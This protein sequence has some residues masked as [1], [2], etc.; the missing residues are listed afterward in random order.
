MFVLD[1][2]GLPLSNTLSVAVSAVLATRMP[3][4]ERTPFVNV[5]NSDVP[6]L[7]AVPVLLVTVGT[8][9]LGDVLSPLKVSV[10]SPL[11]VVTV[12]PN[13]S[14][15]VIVS[16]SLTPTVGVVLAAVI[17]Y[18]LA[19][20][21]DTVKLTPAPPVEV[22]DR[23]PSET[24]SV[25][26]STFLATRTP[27]AELT[28]LVNVINSE[29]PSLTGVPVL[30]VIVGTLPAS[31]VPSP[32]KVSVLSPLKLV[33]V[34]PNWSTCVIVSWSLA[35]AAGVVLA[36]VIR[37]ALAVAALTI[38]PLDVAPVSPL[39]LAVRVL[40]VPA[41]VGLI[42]LKVAIPLDAATVSV[43]PV[44][45]V[46]ALPTV[47]LALLRVT[48]LLFWSCTIT[49]TAGLMATPAVVS[50]GCCPACSPFRD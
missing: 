46:L 18:A 14:T 22:L 47:T 44:N 5:I 33:T 49:V 27:P 21:A 37:Y 19:V 6:S 4:A 32:L 26:V 7:T 45:A 11:K 38:N 48:V 31:E 24:L 36:A 30:S 1:K 2:T 8:A 13:W 43:L 34:F 41:V 23:L 9:P 25:A 39:L 12:F 29:V 28:P 35:P 17:R 40:L 16:W 15:S 42:P 10:L 3:P 50:V 20:V